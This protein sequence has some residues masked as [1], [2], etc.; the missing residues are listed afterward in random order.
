MVN[1][2]IISDFYNEIIR[3]ETILHLAIQ[4]ID[5]AHAPDAKD[6]LSLDWEDIWNALGCEI[7]ESESTPEEISDYLRN[8]G[9][10][11]FLVKFATPVPQYID[12]DG[13][14]VTWSWYATKWIYSETLEGACQK[15]LKW[16]SEYIENKKAKAA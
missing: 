7:P 16:K 14:S 15:A 13:Y 3:A 6:A 12:G 2:Q 5:E 11:G 10:N 4:C 9:I 8:K 1:L